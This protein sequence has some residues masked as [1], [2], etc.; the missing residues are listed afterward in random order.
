MTIYCEFCRKQA[1]YGNLEIDKKN[2]TRYVRRFCKIH[3]NG[4]KYLNVKYCSDEKCSIIP[5]LGYITNKP[6]A[7]LVH[8]EPGMKNVTTRKCDECNNKQP[9]FNFDNLPPKYCGDCIFE[10]DGIK[11]TNTKNI[12][13][14]KINDVLNDGV[15][16]VLNDG[17]NDN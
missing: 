3:S 12:R 7:C 2:V 15:N 8:S 16:D 1:F 10:K 5:T 14:R 6:I 13:K 4:A 17:V 9:S 11:M